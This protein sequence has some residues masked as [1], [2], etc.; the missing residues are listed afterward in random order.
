MAKLP[1][2]PFR[3]PIADRRTLLI[4]RNWQQFFQAFLDRAGG[5]GDVSSNAELEMAVAGDTPFDSLALWQ[6]LAQR[7][8]DV[9]A[10]SSF[11]ERLPSVQEAPLPFTDATVAALGTLAQQVQDLA[12]L[13]IFSQ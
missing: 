12:V 3:I 11:V 5:V 10:L 2:V 8:T 9:E 1:P 7:V 4:D 13:E 6:A